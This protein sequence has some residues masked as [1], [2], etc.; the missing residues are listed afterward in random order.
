MVQDLVRFWD[1]LLK[2]RLFRHRGML[3][4]MITFGPTPREVTS[5]YALGVEQYTLPSASS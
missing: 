5:G 1:A 3:K 2:R 4:E